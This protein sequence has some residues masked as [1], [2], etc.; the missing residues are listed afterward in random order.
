LFLLCHGLLHHGLLHRR[1]L[2]HGLLHH[3]LLLHGLLHHRHV[4]NVDWLL[5]HHRLHGGTA[6]LHHHG[7]RH[8][9]GLEWHSLLI[10]EAFIFV[11]VVF[12]DFEVLASDFAHASIYAEDDPEEELCKRETDRDPKANVEELHGINGILK[13]ILG[14]LSVILLERVDARIDHLEVLEYVQIGL[15]S[16]LVVASAV[17]EPR[18]P[19]EHCKAA[20][21]VQEE[22]HDAASIVNVLA[23]DQ[24]VDENTHD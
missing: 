10:N 8:E 6:W 19:D 4:L 7:H 9:A 16:S 18:G 2:H 3:G 12:E 24:A 13:R 22:H 5:L 11:F 1:L 20:R 15:S 17:T 21:I 14:R 23:F